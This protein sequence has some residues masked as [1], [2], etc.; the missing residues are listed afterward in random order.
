[1]NRQSDTDSLIGPGGVVWFSRAELACKATG[2]LRLAPGFADA[3][4][5]LRGRL[6]RPMIVT[7]CCRSVDYNRSIGGHRR[8]LHVC[9]QP[10]HPIGGAAAIDIARDPDEAPRL[11]E[12]ALVLGW[13]VGI[14][15]SFIHLDWRDL[16]RLPR[17][18]FGYGGR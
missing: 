4:L 8:S 3:L 11:V 5:A 10:Y 18:I 1:M 2:Q 12:L 7:S 13:S 6:G 17:R 14:S 16:A 9:D 15:L